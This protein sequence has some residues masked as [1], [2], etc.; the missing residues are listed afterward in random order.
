MSETP[1]VAAILKALKSAG[2]WSFRINSGR[3]KVRGGMFS[4]APAGTPDILV[5]VRPSPPHVYGYLV[6][7]EVKTNDKASKQ[8]DSQKKWQALA[9]RHGV[10]YA[11]VRSAAEALEF[12]KGCK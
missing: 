2:F 7:L 8:E 10:P 4:G 5:V 3:V 6:G 1:I 9:A 11:V 12:L